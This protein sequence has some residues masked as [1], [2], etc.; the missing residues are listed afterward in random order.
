M[1]FWTQ[2]LGKTLAERKGRP[3]CNAVILG[4]A[5][6]GFA[7]ITH[8]GWI[9]YNHLGKKTKI[10]VLDVTDV[11]VE[12]G[13]E[14]VR[15]STALR[16]GGGAAAGLVLLGPVG[17]L[18]GLG[19]GALAKKESGGEKFLVVES[20]DKTIF[21]QVPA[22]EVGKAQEFRQSVRDARPDLRDS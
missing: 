1:G 22:K 21:L 2:P 18:A 10:D 17:M 12:D 4:V 8:D 14:L 5:K 15:K 9:K 16:A 6:T 7:Q 3:F 11:R 20:D 19:V 13:T